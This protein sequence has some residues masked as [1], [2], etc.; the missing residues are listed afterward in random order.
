MRMCA[1]LCSTIA[2]VM[3]LV[4]ALSGPAWAQQGTAA[5]QASA[6]PPPIETVPGTPQQ[7]Q[8][9]AH[10]AGDFASGGQDF[11][12]L[13]T[14]GGLALVICLLIAGVIGGKKFLPQYFAKQTGDKQLKLLES[15]AM[16]DK[17]SVALIQVD[18]KILLVGNTP[19]QITLL[20]N[21]SGSLSLAA[22]PEL[23]PQTSQPSTAARTNGDSFRSLY[24]VEKKQPS[25]GTPKVIPPDIRAKM[26]QLREALEH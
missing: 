8:S 25:R 11:P 26:R 17:R 3:W 24:E 2:I 10:S 1:T 5:G 6:A 16:G 19:Q 7:A 14:L 18:D 21:I 4:L 15:L 23:A 12:I 9:P 20:A 22:T 13:R